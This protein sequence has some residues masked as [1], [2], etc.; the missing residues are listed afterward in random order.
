MSEPLF[1]ILLLSAIAGTVV[2]QWM[3]KKDQ[4]PSRAGNWLFGCMAAACLCMFI[5]YRFDL[6]W[7]MPARIVSDILAPYV[8]QWIK[9]G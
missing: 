7:P 9:G 5:L 4:P 2:F 3:T 6:V 1:M 8:E